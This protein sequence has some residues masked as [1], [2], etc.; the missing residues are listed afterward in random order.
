MDL[1]ERHIRTLFDFLRTSNIAEFDISWNKIPSAMLA[2]LF[3]SLETNMSIQNL[4]LG[5]IQMGA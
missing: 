5:W 3:Q 2:Y 1:S 4:N